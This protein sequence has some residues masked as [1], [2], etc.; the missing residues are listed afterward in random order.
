MVALNFILGINFKIIERYLFGYFSNSQSKLFTSH[1]LIPLKIVIL[2]NPEFG[3]IVN[4][5]VQLGWVD[6]K[7]LLFIKI[8]SLK[9][10]YFLG[11]A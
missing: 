6:E 4:L 2:L 7:L 11:F 9:F 5:R 3:Q 10:S 8:R 1:N